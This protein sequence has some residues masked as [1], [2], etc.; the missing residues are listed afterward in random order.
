MTRTG[1]SLARLGLTEPRAEATVTELGWW[2]GDKPAAG[3]EPVMWALARS[4]DPDLALRSVERL[5]QV[6]PDRAELDEALRTDVVLRGRLLAL[7]GSSTALADHLVTHPDRWHRLTESA[8][9]AGEGATAALLRA[10]GADPD[11]QPAGGPGGAAATLTGAEA[12]GAL[13]TAYRDEVLVLAAADL[14]AVGEPGLPVLDVEDVAAQLA[15]LA[16]AALQAALAVAVAEA[17]G[18]PGRLA[19]I[20][21]G[22]CGGHELNYVSDVDVVFVAEPA[23]QATT[24]LAGRVMRVAG[25]ACFQVDANLRP[26]GR[27]GALVRTLDGHVSYYQ[28]WAKTWEFQALLKARPVAGDPELGAAYAD[29]V[30]PL[31]WSAAGRD[32]FVADVQAMRRRVEDHIRPDHAERELKL[33]RGGLRDVEFAVQLLQLVHGR[34]DETLRSPSTLEALAALAEGGY[35]GREDG[36]NLAA[37]YRFLR[38]LEHRLQLERMRRTHLLPAPDD[39]IGLRWLARA[40]RLRPDGRRDVVGVLTTEWTR[41]ARRVRRLH[42]KLFY[43]PLLTAVSRLPVDTA[44]L[45]EQAA[46]ARLAAL[47]WASPEGALGHLRALTAGVSRAASIQQTLLPV[48]L[49]EL[50]HTPDPDRGL[51]AY[52]R[53]SEALATTPWY[54][55]LLRDEGLVAD[56]LMRLLGT[57]ALV[58]DLLVRAPEV[59]RMLAAPVPGQPDELLR[60]PAEVA[61]S[62][63]TTVA[64]QHDPES[65]AATAR[66]LRRHE[67]LRVACA[68]LLGVLPAEQVCAAL[69]AV[70]VAVLQATIESVEREIGADPRPAAVAVIGMG[71]LGGA[72]LGYGSDADVLFVCEPANGASDHDAV[73]YATAV[74]EAVRKRLAAPSPDPALVVDADLRPEGRSGPLVRTLESYRSYYARWS[75]KWE[76]Q[77]LL[78]ASAVAGDADLGRRFLHMADPIRYPAEGIDAAVVTEIRR[79]KARVDAERLPRGADRTTHT[80]LGLGGLADVEWTVQLLQL[81]HAGD[82]PELRTTSTLEGLL[83][84]SEADLI[85]ADDAA[86]LAAGWTMATR[87]RNA[88]MLVKGKPGD[89]LPRSGRELAA[90]AS[91]L[92]YP[93]GGDPGVFLDDYRRTTRRARAVVERVFYGW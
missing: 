93:A 84:A 45:S 61:A 29:A 37:S 54:L 24:R 10:V 51:L 81:Q 25:D 55:R 48:L 66:S 72:E 13:R 62:L 20:A 9:P 42:E 80:K 68:D 64:R 52:R 91:A 17:D 35:V 23:D 32:D 69:S 6:V 49:D 63:R 43:R 30:A 70:W 16:A 56:R 90:V 92:G 86:A 58:P 19:V 46:A 57:S 15:D 78:R 47:G 89:Q 3:A 65:A 7:L 21:M 53:V 28:R 2:A 22:K 71:R 12:I 11:G 85:S 38:L 60:D 87:A 33:G 18:D 27:D 79:I 75:E 76:A 44:R 59:L 83:E 5:V 26:E 39:T 4:P 74:A 50:A 73:R 67:M 40:A 77:A 34:T 88:V 36:A 82:I 1:S 41:N 8:A 14:A 31:V